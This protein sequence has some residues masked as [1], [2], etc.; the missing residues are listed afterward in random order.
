LTHPVSHP[1]T[2]AALRHAHQVVEE[3]TLAGDFLLQTEWQA[4]TKFGGLGGARDAR[5]ALLT[6]V[7]TYTLPFVPAFAWI[8]AERDAG[9]ALGMVAAV[10]L[11]HL[12]IDDGRV[13]RGWMHAVKHSDRPAGGLLVAVDQS[14]HALCLLGAA[15]LAA[16]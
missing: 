5:R 12:V 3:L 6:H 8:A 16:A 10:A 11:P 7:V 15:L 14:F 13:V 1:P 2:L 9:T 4:L